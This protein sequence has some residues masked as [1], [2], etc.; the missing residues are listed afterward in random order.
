MSPSF[1]NLPEEDLQEEEEEIDFSGEYSSLTHGRYIC[2]IIVYLDL[3]EQYEVRLEEGLDTFVVIDG[4]PIV[5]EESKAK[6]VKF[7]LQKK[8]NTVGK[9]REDA[10]F[11]PLDENNMTQ[12][13]VSTG[14]PGLLTLISISQ[15]RLCRIRNTRSSSRR[16]QGSSWY[17]IG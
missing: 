15:V 8:L 6:L 11:M 17:A 7:L 3:R 5:P 2:L 10:I 4:L 14:P 16:H 12:G 13:C 1:K 9:T